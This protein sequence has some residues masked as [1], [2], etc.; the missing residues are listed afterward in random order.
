MGNA[1]LFSFFKLYRKIT[2]LG[3]VKNRPTLKKFSFN[4]E[5]SKISIVVNG[6]FVILLLASSRIESTNSC[7]SNTN[8]CFFLLVLR[9]VRICDLR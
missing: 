2:E 1:N 4:W 6:S 9:N 8:V 5:G 7:F 3:Q